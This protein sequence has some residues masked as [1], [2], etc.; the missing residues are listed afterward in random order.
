MPP[1]AGKDTA[2][3]DLARIA[4]SRGFIPLS[5]RLVSRFSSEVAGR[6]LFLIDVGGHGLGW[7]AILQAVL[8]TPQ[9][10]V[11]LFAG[12]T[13]FRISNFK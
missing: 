11:L 13:K 4:R 2:I 6:S 5:T 3:D 7:N 10:H 12:L 8:T 9:S 1:G